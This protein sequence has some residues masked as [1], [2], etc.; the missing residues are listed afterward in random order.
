MIRSFTKIAA[1]G[2]FLALLAS[3]TAPA[4]AQE[5]SQKDL[6]SK[7]FDPEWAKNLGIGDPTLFLAF[8]SKGEL[9]GALTED[10][11]KDPSNGKARNIKP[12]KIPD[13]LS[14]LRDMTSFSILSW[15]GSNCY[16]VRGADG[17]LYVM[18]PGCQ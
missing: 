16:L 5:L 3:S 18:P 8:N 4:I 17:T 12:S 6:P 14:G 7:T 2:L 10:H 13:K 15:T 11:P 1:A 9:V